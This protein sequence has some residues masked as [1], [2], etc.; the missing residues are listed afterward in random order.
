MLAHILIWLACAL[1]GAW[2]AVSARSSVTAR[3]LDYSDRGLLSFPIRIALVSAGLVA[4]QSALVLL[5]NHNCEFRVQWYAAL[6][7][8]L[9]TPAT[10]VLMEV[11]ARWHL[12]PNRVV[13]PVAG[14]LLPVLSILAIDRGNWE[15]LLRVWLWS[16]GMGLLLFAASFFGLGMGDVKLGVILAAWMGLYD[17]LAPMIM[18][19]LA[20]VLGGIFAMCR[21][22]ARKATLRSH[23]AF[24]PWL[25]V[26]AY[27][28]W[29]LYL[30]SILNP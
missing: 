16:L 8:F 29:L 14:V 9:L 21:I 13:L 20:S 22:L 23:I 30:P 15:A 19:F 24:G 6:P 18:L 5:L 27:L 28:T 4:C 26:G 11:D 1:I 25:I 7:A 17:W 12:L 2:C 10:L 3:N